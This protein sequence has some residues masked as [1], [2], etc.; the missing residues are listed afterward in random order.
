MI[1]KREKKNIAVLESFRMCTEFGLVMGS[2]KHYN[3]LKLVVCI[4]LGVL[5]QVQGFRLTQYCFEYCI[6]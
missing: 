3:D 1:R 2:H 6:Q 5:G 4:L